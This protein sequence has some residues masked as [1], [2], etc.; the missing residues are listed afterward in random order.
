[1]SGTSAISVIPLL[2]SNF[3]AMVTYNVVDV[4]AIQGQLEFVLLGLAVLCQYALHSNSSM[5]LTLFLPMNVFWYLAVTSL[6]PQL[7]I[8]C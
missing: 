4:S 1:M 3:E 2:E 7:R 8:A 6:P 5:A